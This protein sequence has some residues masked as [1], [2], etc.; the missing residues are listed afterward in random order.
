MVNLVLQYLT[1]ALGVSSSWKLVK[2]HITTLLTNCVFPL[3]CFDDEDAE[4]WEDDPQEYIRKV[5]LSS[6]C[7]HAL[8]GWWLATGF[9]V[10]L[11]VDTCMLGQASNPGLHVATTFCRQCVA[12]AHGRK[13]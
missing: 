10:L 8:S 13:Q 4:L 2:P 5:L 3:M 11:E 1:H 12:G 9:P 7:R 6:F